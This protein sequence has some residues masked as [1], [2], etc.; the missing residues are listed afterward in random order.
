MC[1]GREQGVESGEGQLRPVVSP[2]LLSEGS[3]RISQGQPESAE[4]FWQ[5][6]WCRDGNRKQTAMTKP[7]VQRES[8]YGAM[9][10]T[11]RGVAGSPLAASLAVLTGASRAKARSGSRH[12][13]ARFPHAQ[14]KA[15]HLWCSW[16]SLLYRLLFT[17]NNSTL[18]LVTFQHVEGFIRV[19]NDASIFQST[20]SRFFHLF[21]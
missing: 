8:L 17:V 2:L 20:Q 12:A 16:Y 11:W 7:C 14:T 9:R 15:P 5:F 19:H 3:A 1:V 6:K 21:N 10:R 18:S 13:R 4:I